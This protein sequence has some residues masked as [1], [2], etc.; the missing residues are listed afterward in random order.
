M[1]VAGKTGAVYDIDPATGATATVLT[2]GNLL[3]SGEGGLLAVLP[4]A[5]YGSSGGSMPTR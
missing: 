1:L 4:A 3:T 2:A 5:D